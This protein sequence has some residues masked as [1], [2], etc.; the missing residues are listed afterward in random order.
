[1]AAGQPEVIEFGSEFLLGVDLWPVWN[2]V[3]CPTLVLRGAESGV[4][5]AATADRMPNSGPPTRIVEFAGI[6]LAPGDG[7][8]SDRCHLRL[9]IC[10]GCSNCRLTSLHWTLYAAAIGVRL[11]HNWRLLFVFLVILLFLV[12]IGGDPSR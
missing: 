10:S 4:L 9:F 7:Q 12:I 6:G 3:R 8:R 2:A 1:V 11:A 5:S